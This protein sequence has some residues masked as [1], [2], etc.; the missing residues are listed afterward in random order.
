[1]DS[2]KLNFYIFLVFVTVLSIS[3]HDNFAIR[4]VLDCYTIVSK[5]SGYNLYIVLDDIYS[6]LTFLTSEA[7]IKYHCRFLMIDTLEFSG[8]VLKT[9]TFFGQSF[10]NSRLMFREESSTSLW[11]IRGLCAVSL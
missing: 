9:G 6:I 11:S 5:R 7:H 2:S 3:N 4:M 1:M 10:I 8:K